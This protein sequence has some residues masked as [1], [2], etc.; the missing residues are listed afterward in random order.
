MITVITPTTGK[1]SLLNTIMSLKNQKTTFKIKHIILW[2]NKRDGNFLFPNSNNA[3]GSPYDLQISTQNYSCDCIVLNEDF[4]QG[5]AAGSALRAVGLMAVN[6]DLVTFMD[7]DVMWDSNHLESI[8]ESI[9]DKEWVFCKRRIWT[10]R[11]TNIEGE[12]G[13][14]CLGIDEFES[15]GEEAKTPYKMVDNNSMVFKAK[16]GYSAACLYRNTKFY[17]DDRLMYNFLLKYAGQ[18]AKTNLATVNQICPERLISYF[19]SNCTKEA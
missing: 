6:T 5:V 16:Y 8:L 14:E 2:D 7:D 18:P 4:V 10:N 11:Q 15:V 19:R 17:D 13:F 12:E 3:V 9:N 1:E